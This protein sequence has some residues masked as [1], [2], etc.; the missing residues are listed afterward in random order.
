VL[1][2]FKS[3][4][5]VTGIDFEVDQFALAMS[6]LSHLR[7]APGGL[8]VG[9]PASVL[10]GVLAAGASGN[11]F[12]ASPV[13][14]E[15][16]GL[17]DGQVALDTVL[18]LIGPRR[19]AL[20]QLAQGRAASALCKAMWA[21]DTAQ[22]DRLEGA[23]AVLKA[24]SGQLTA[25]LSRVDETTGASALQALVMAETLATRF[26]GAQV[27]QLKPVAAGGATLAKTN[28]FTTSFYFSGGAIV[29]Y[30]LYDGSSGNVV[31]AGTMPYYAGFIKADRLPSGRGGEPAP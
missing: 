27:L 8:S 15:L 16:N 18:R 11:V 20:R 29:S 1:S 30:L 9:Y 19:D 28:L 14:K 22:L 6:V 13:L 3:D 7:R 5:K 12:T 4:K 23:V 31:L 2:L 17:V 25:A 21:R 26:A 24:A 10:P